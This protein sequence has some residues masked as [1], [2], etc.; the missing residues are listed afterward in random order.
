MSKKEVNHIK[1]WSI[2]TLVILTQNQEGGNNNKGTDNEARPHLK[3]KSPLDLALAL[4]TVESLGLDKARLH[5]YKS[6]LR[7]LL[8][9]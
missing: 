4:D 5:V 7:L 1:E 9:E 6:L 8:T 3:S 2:F